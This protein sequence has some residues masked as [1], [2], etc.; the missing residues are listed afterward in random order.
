MEKERCGKKVI[1]II[2]RYHVG[3]RD[4]VE[5][6]D[7]TTPL[8]RERYTGNWMGAMQGRKPNANIIKALLQIYGWSMG[9]GLGGNNHSSSIR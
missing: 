3:F 5:V 1:D 7:V 2:S 4:R 9:R 8:T 6:I